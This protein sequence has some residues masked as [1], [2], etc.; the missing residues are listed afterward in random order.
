MLISSKKYPESNY[1][2]SVLET[3]SVLE[4]GDDTHNSLLSILDLWLTDKTTFS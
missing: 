1:S 2:I 4:K 3:I